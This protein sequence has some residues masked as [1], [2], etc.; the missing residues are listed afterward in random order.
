MKYF[1]HELTREE[2]DDQVVKLDEL[3]RRL[4]CL[5][6]RLLDAE[7]YPNEEEIIKSTPMDKIIVEKE[8]Q[9]IVFL[10]IDFEYL[11][12]RV[13]SE[14]INRLSEIYP[15]MFLKRAEEML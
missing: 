7:Y 9:D 1:N 5:E 10:L 14:M 12:K 11:Y 8:F 13:P 6:D 2:V 3:V 4:G 15:E